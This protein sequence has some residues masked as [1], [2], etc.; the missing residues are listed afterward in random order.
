[1]GEGDGGDCPVKNVL[2]DSVAVV[3]PLDGP[4]KKLARQLDFTG[5][6][7]VSGTVASSE[8]PQL[9]L[10]PQPRPQSVPRGL[11]Q[12]T[13]V[14]MPVPPQVPHSSVRVGKPESPKSRSRPNFETKDSTPKKQKQCNCKH[15]RCLKLYCECFASGIYCEGCNCVNCFNNVENDAARR[16]AVEATL[17]RN[18][19]A[20]R[21]KIASS[22]HGTRNS[23]EETGE[24]LVLGKHNK[25]C[26][27]KKSG[28]LKK[29]CECFQANILCSENCKCFDCKN[30]EGSEERQA[31]FHGD[32]NNNITY[33]QQAANAAITGAIGTSGYSSPP[34]SKKRKG[35]EPFFGPTVK[36]PSVGRLGQF[37]QANNVGVPTPSSSLSSVPGA[38]V[39]GAAV[40]PS[41]FAYRSLL[42][43]IIHPQ[44]LKELCSVL[45]LVSGQAAKTLS[46]PDQKTLLDKQRIEDQTETAL[47]SSTQQQLL[48]QVETDVEK[49]MADDCLS[50]NQTDKIDPDYSSSDG[51]DVSKGR[52]M[53]P[54]TLA[55]MCD[56]R[57]AMFMTA[58]S[59]NSLMMTHDCS[60]SSQS[61]CGQGM[62]EVHAEQ[63]RIV[64]TKFRDFLNRVI[65]MGEINETKC[66]SLARSVLETQKDPVNNNVGNTSTKTTHHQQIATSNGVA[67]AAVPPMATNMNIITSTALIP[68]NLIPDGENKPKIEKEI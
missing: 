47:A 7:G 43:D 17:E 18:P 27:C 6:G 28:C 16:E 66:S 3:L 58:P 65:T 53:S 8:H 15:S 20:F 41:K 51:A 11:T 67:K 9:Q 36:D 21:P 49:T 31:L 55:L 45:V 50:A 32:Q 62:T 37:Q 60:A 24:V 30:F 61:A 40:G 48:S 2:S 23:K 57:D 42:A 14:V 54:G 29:Y 63:E 56:E 46:G 19:N 59:P 22:P 4:G 39:G 52:P 1:M 34:I 38:W 10:Q 25:G 64:L 26:H 68:N 5:F 44:H 12:Q 35:Q 13:M 33:I